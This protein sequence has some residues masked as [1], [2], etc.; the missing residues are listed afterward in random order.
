MGDPDDYER[1]E[2]SIRI[3]PSPVRQKGPRESKP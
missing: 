1:H 3:V 2:T